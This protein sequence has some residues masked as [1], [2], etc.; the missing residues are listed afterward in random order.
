MNFLFVTWAG[1]G[2]VTPVVGL[3]TRLLTRGHDVK[4]ASP[5]D[6]HDRFAAAGVEDEVFAFDPGAVLSVIEREAPDVVIVDFMMPTWMSQTEASGRPWVALVHTLYD[7]VAAGIITAFTTLDAINDE[8]RALGLDVLGD[9]PALLD[10]AARVL[11]TAPAELD[12]AVDL[13]A[14]TAHIG[15]ILEEAGPDAGWA[16][17]WPDRPLVVV[18]PGTTPGLGEE[19]LIERALAAVSGSNLHALISVA[20]HVDQSAFDVPANAALIGYVR[21]AAVLPHADAVVTH[22]GLGSITAALA[23]GLPLLCVP[24]DRDQ[25]HN[26]ERVVAVGA[27]ESLAVEASAE[28]Y[29]DAIGRVLNDDRYRAVAAR[30]AAEYDPSAELAIGELEALG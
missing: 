8:R 24:L 5:N 3:A 13:P 17:P 21:H 19:R 12:E 4:V 15:T 10:R 16:P 28:A 30:L 27:G 7:G 26:A 6:L 23:H 1:G 22:A 18:S 2:N 20:P 11:I 9:A 29:R 14:N 25:P